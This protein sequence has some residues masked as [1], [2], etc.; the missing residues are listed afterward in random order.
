MRVLI[1]GGQGNAAIEESSEVRSKRERSFV[2]TVKGE[3][4]R[5]REGRGSQTERQIE[6]QRKQERGRLMVG[7]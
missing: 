3:T 2:K 4:E 6:R 1:T 7:A 5:V